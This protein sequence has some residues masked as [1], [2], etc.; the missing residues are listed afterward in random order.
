M[1]SHEHPAQPSRPRPYELFGFTEQEALDGRVSHARLDEIL[2]DER[3]AVHSAEASYNNYGEFL[4]LTLSRLT[5]RQRIGVSFYGLGFHEYRERW[6][7]GEWFWYQTSLSLIDVEQALPKEEVEPI[8]QR[9][10][11]DIR[12]M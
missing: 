7:T 9:R 12:P 10:L 4:F 11:A 8:I 2:Q 6:L 1:M 5:S 3:T